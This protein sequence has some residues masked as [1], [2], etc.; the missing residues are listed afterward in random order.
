[1][2]PKKKTPKK[3][4]HVPDGLA[5]LIKTGISTAFSEISDAAGVIKV[6]QSKIHNVDF[7]FN[8]RHSKKTLMMLLSRSENP[9]L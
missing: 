7:Q 2:S 6:T 8:I 3:Q 4:E 9:F 1:M 5:E